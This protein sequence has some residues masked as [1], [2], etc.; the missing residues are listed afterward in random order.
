[1]AEI[2]LSVATRQT[3]KKAVKA[4][5]NSGLIPGVFYKNGVE[6]IAIS[7]DLIKLRPIIYTNEA[8]TVQLSI[9]GQTTSYKT[10]LKDVSFDPISD[11]VLHF[12]LMGLDDDQ[13]ITVIVPIKLVGQ[14]VGVKNGGIMQHVI[15]KIKITCKA[16]DLPQFITVDISH[17]EIG[18][19]FN[20]DGLRNE[21]YDFAIKDNAVICSIAKP[22]VKGSAGK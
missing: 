10:F 17:L 4:T 18:Q 12:D 2:A 8:N 14:S 13:K 15:R 19:S 16:K 6:P 22:R 21:L 9:E 3:G 11:K 1:M 5:R 20:L 7:S